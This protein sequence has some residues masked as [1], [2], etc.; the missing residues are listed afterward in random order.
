MTILAKKIR[1]SYMI[2]VL[3]KG[4][5]IGISIAAPVGP[6]GILCMNRTITFGKRGGFVSGLGA[7]TADALYGFMAA[8]GLVIV[9]GLFV[10]N[11]LWLQLL[12]GIFLSYLGMKTFF[13]KENQKEANTKKEQA[14][15]RAFISTFFLTVA[16]PMTIFSFLAI[17]SSFGLANESNLGLLFVFGVFLGSAFWWWLLSQLTSRLIKRT[18]LFIPLVNKVSGLLLIGFSLWSFYEIWSSLS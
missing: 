3:I 17:L 4:F 13:A 1:S 8:F 11:Q 7:A 5:I 6:V 9:T 12:G 10:S 15:F 14:L 16:N 2:E 18:S